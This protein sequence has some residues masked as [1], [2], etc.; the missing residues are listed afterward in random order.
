MLAIAIAITAAGASGF[1]PAAEQIR[2][3]RHDKHSHPDAT[4]ARILD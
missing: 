4:K 2:Q 1:A 3:L